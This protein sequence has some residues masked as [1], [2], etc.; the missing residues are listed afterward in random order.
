MPSAL[1]KLGDWEVAL[2]KA[3][4]HT[5]SRSDQD[6]LAY[7]TWPTR[8]IN[9]REIAQIRTGAKHRQIEPA[10]PEALAAFLS[11]WPE[12][13][14]G[15]GLSLDADQLLVKAR[16]AMVAAVQTFNSAGLSFRAEL[17]IVTS[18]IAWTYLMHAALK[19]EGV[20]VRYWEG[21]GRD[22]K[23]KTTPGG[24]EKYWEL[25][26]CLRH[27]KCRLDVGTKNNLFY[28]LE[29]RHE[30]EHRSTDRSLDAALS[31]KLQACCINFNDAL[32]QL[33]GAKYGLERKLS[34]AL[35]FASLD[36]EQV[37]AVRSADLPPHLATVMDAF[38][39]QLTPEQYSDPRYAYRV[40]MVPRHANRASA[41]DIVAE[42][43]PSGSDAAE[44]INRVLL[45]ETER[46]KYRPG[47]ILKKAHEAG[48]RYFKM[49]DHTTLW[50]RLDA[51]NPAKHFGVDVAGTWY[52]YESWL[53]HVLKVLGERAAAY[54]ASM[55]RL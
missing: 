49:H 7:F 51:K 18:I 46:T 9:H 2:I 8:S 52:W 16:D 41:A 54:A 45:R 14:P 44:E 17:F 3:L 27:A 28:L 10:S 21:S 1:K 42:L 32:K 6:V 38:E 24:G 12:V 15:T 30:I 5:G 25:G 43:V 13:E 35:Q 34:L 47:D 50:Q 55:P 37:G 53:Q 11:A 4:L 20:D 40:A 29:I 36:P 23:V 33:Y 26:Q 48:Y 39:A 19:K 31:A 22:R